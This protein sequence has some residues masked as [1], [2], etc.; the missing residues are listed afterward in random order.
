M[1]L[2]LLY[3]ILCSMFFS[4][5]NKIQSVKKRRVRS[6]LGWV[7]AGET[8]FRCNFNT[9]QLYYLFLVLSVIHNIDP[10]LYIV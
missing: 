7:T 3:F 5:N 2:F 8:A 10:D 4:Y 6:V 9:S 1:L